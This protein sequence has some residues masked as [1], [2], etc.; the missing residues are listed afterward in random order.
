MIS[1]PRWTIV[2]DWQFHRFLHLASRVPRQYS[3]LLYGDRHCGSAIQRA[4]GTCDR[5]RVLPAW[6]PWLTRALT[7]VTAAAGLKEQC[8]KQQKT[9][10]ECER[11]G[12]PSLTRS[13]SKH[14][15]T[16]NWQP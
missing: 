5:D 1:H 9:C 4:G 15:E 13:N 7:V 2:S 11:T 8:S 10:H 6:G 12:S 14:G 3:A 16:D